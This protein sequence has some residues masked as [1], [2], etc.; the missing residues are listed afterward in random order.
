M[1]DESGKKILRPAHSAAL[2]DLKA[3]FLTRKRDAKRAQLGHNDVHLAKTGV[4]TITKQEKAVQKEKQERRRQTIEHRADLLRKEEAER[5][6]Q[7]KTMEEKSRLYERMTNGEE[8]TYEDGTRAD[9]RTYG[10]SHLHLSQNE[11]ERAKKIDELKNISKQTDSVRHKRKKQLDEKKRA[12]REKTKRLRAKLNLPPLE[13]TSEES[14]EDETPGPSLDEIP[15]PPSTS[16]PEEK[17]KFGYAREWDAGKDG[18]NRW[19]TRERDKR[20][21][22]FRPPTSYYDR[23]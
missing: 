6:R 9:G 4:L 19:L 12:A 17:K 16:K 15:L 3:E 7:R 5:E 20:D 10:P 11:E 1:S 21:D 23:K 13:S 18:Y 22:D 8:V 14:E 2:I